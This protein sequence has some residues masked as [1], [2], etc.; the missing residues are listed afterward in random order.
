MAIQVSRWKDNDR[1]QKEYGLPPGRPQIATRDL[2]DRYIFFK[3]LNSEGDGGALNEGINIVRDKKTGKR[4]VQKK[5]DPTQRVLLRELILLQ[6]LRHPNIIEYV[7]GFFDKSAWHHHEASLYLQ[8]CGLGDVQG[9]LYK[10]YE[11]NIKRAEVDKVYIPEA[12]IWHMFR[13]LAYA[14]QYLHF[15]LTVDDQRSPEELNAVIRDPS[16][17][18]EVWPMIMHRDIKPENIFFRK[19]QPR[20][21]R[22]VQQ[23][24]LFHILPVKKESYAVSPQFPRVVLGD[25]VSPPKCTTKAPET[26]NESQGLALQHND[27]D[28]NEDNEAVGTYRWMPPEVPKAYCQGDIWAVGAVILALCRQMLGGVVKPAPANWSEGEEAWSRHRDARKGI[29]DLGVGRRYSPELDHVVHEC[30]RFNRLNRPLAFQL[31]AMINEGEKAAG[32]KGF[33][34]INMFPRWVWGGAEDRVHRN[35]EEKARVAAKRAERLKSPED[36]W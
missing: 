24:K 2:S 31:L 6:V 32:E 33:L 29:R 27:D 25:F 7:D 18:R 21:T 9:L 8:F 19:T 10:Y 12:F 13:S 30:L 26:Y 20:L 35:K 11:H 17:M 16:Y 23:R 3:K 15:G 34:E 1:F 36:K 22:V 28:W 5:L 14:L 4:L